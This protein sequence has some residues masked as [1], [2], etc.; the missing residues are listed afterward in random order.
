MDRVTVSW[1]IEVHH[2]TTYHYSGNVESSYNEARLT[3]KTGPRQ[4]V[5]SS[6]IEVN[7]RVTPF[8]YT[9][10]FG[11]TVNSFDLHQPHNLLTVVGNSH[12]ETSA[13]QPIVT[14]QSAAT[15]RR[16]HPASTRTVTATGRARGQSCV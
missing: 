7:P 9:D 4:T 16:R 8:R 14:A 15:D 12:T 5:L 10:A 3:P 2:A 13:P 1:R 11:T 6:S